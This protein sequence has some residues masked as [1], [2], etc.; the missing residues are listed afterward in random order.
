[1]LGSFAKQ[2]KGVISK[3][4][5]QKLALIRLGFIDA[6][7]W[8]EKI[9]RSDISSKAFIAW[10]ELM[11]ICQKCFR[12]DRA[13]S[14]KCLSRICAA[15]DVGHETKSDERDACVLLKR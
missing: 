15:Y 11:S 12:G 5:C 6:F 14:N 10:S 8:G 1:V 7:I 13:M 9:D 3:Y 4:E 2:A